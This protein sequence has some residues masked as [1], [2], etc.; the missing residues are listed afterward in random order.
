MARA[1]VLAGLGTH[2][3][4][5]VLTNDMLAEVLDTSDTWIRTRTGIRQR[6]VADERTTTG[7]LAVA[8]GERALASAGVARVDVV[9]LAT[10]TP[11]RQCP[12]TAPTVASRLGLSGTPAFDVQAACTGFVYGLATVSS[13]ITAGL[14]ETALFIGADK[15][16]DTLDPG[17]RS[18]RALIGDGAG[19]VV[20]RAGDSDED[21]ALLA[22]DL[23]SD[24]EHVGLLEVPA[25]NRVE[26]A[27]GATRGYFHMEGKPVFTKAVTAM[28]DSVRRVLDR[29]GWATGEVDRLVP[30]Q[31]NARI[32]AA[33]ADQLDL[34]ADRL[35]SN[36]SDVGNTVA[37]S[38]P[39]AL[40]HGMR[41]QGLR[42][43]HNVVLT[44]FGA[45]LTWGSV[46]VR[47]PK[48]ND[49]GS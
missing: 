27:E 24:G 38:I 2:V 10:T 20:L 18:G 41:H 36:I 5:D 28:T 11:D 49:I 9:V 15:F 12:A 34:P 6:H 42:S 32:L 17:D 13:M 39:L 19:A 1:A 47:W 45:G 23:G 35:V 44:G 48:I 40:G 33:V 22:F 43:G 25:V 3:P 7:D 46:A 26:R 29:V 31:A 16:T 37:A 8:A 30:H 14:F 4:P 21:G